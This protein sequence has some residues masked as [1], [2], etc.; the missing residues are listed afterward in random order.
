M[1]GRQCSDF[2]AFHAHKLDA[3]VERGLDPQVTR[4]LMGTAYPTVGLHS[5]YYDADMDPLCQVVQDTVGRHDSFALACTAR[6][7]EDLGYP[8]HVNCTE[9]FNRQ[10][11][12]YG[13]AAKKGWAALNF[14]YNTSFDPDLVL[15]SD[16]PWSRP[17]DFVLLRAM[18]DLVCAS[19]ACPDDIDPGQRLGDHRRPRPRL[20]T[21]EPL[22]DGHRPPRHPGGRARADQGDGLPLRAGRR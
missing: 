14:F 10:L 11:D 19:S 5:K 21:G 9:N 17:G 20:L 8:G 18:S 12:P 15:L 22:L 7:Y 16:E 2:L 4:T 3:G 13:I 1:A 6:Y